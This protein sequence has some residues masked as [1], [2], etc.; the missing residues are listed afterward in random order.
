[1][2]K[3]KK[4]KKIIIFIYFNTYIFILILFLFRMS[5]E[6]CVMF[7]DSCNNANFELSSLLF[8]VYREEIINYIFRVNQDNKNNDSNKNDDNNDNN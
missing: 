5:S 4:L 6:I 1:M 8:N 3:N 2:Y 7:A